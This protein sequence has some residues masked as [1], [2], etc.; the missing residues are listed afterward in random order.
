MLEAGATNINP[1]LIDEKGIKNE[2]SKYDNH[3]K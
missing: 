2:E 3:K 1:I